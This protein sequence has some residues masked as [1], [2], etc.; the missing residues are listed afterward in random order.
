MNAREDAVKG[1]DTELAW[2]TEAQAAERGRLEKLEQ[3]VRAEKAELDAKA[4]VLARGEGSHDTAV[5]LR[6]RLGGATSYRGR[7]LRPTA[8][9]SGRGA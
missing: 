8:S 4:K 2:S 9:L 1:R 3:E 5:T 7:G 6:E